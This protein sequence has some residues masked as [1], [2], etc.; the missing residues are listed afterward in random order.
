MCIRDRCT[1]WRK[2]GWVPFANVRLRFISYRVTK[3]GWVLWSEVRMRSRQ[4]RKTHNVRRVGKNTG[5]VLSRFWTKVQFITFSDDVGDLMWL[6]THSP[7]CLYYV[8]FRRYRPL[9]LPLSCE[10]DEKVVF[11]LPICRGRG[12]PRFRTCIFKLHSLPTIWP[13]LVDFRSAS[14]ESSWRKKEE[15]RKKNPGKI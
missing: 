3:F 14:A 11:G 6:S 10:V 5:R 2:V 1:V 8:S 9:K 12:Y 15:E 7:N 4:W 13:V